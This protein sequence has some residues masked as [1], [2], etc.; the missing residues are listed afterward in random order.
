MKMW[1]GHPD[2]EINN[3]AEKSPSGNDNFARIIE[4]VEIGLYAS[5]HVEGIVF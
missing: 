5:A 3:P 4:Q 1:L 2:S